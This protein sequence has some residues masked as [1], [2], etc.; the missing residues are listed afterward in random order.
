MLKS[1]SDATNCFTIKDKKPIADIKSRLNQLKTLSNS[2][3][4][5]DKPH[6]KK[7]NSFS[8]SVPNVTIS[9]SSCLNETLKLY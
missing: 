3:K 1:R 9:S 5:K 2:N 7:T 8:F 6:K 4:K